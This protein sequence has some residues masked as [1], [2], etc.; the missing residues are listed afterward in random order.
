MESESQLETEASLMQTLF[1]PTFSEMTA[2]S[3]PV[4]IS[5]LETIPASLGKDLRGLGI[6][7]AHCGA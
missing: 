5:P 1:L 3:I 4:I 2:E 7:H 6:P